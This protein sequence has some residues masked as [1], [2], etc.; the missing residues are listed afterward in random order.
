MC[1]LNAASH[2]ARSA[3]IKA[4]YVIDSAITAW[5]EEESRW[6]TPLVNDLFQLVSSSVAD[7][8]GA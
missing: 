3:W 5:E 2:P 7:G 6:T 1:E 8:R 4:L